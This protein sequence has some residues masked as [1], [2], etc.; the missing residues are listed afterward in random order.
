MLAN[1]GNRPY[2]VS[3]GYIRYVHPMLGEIHTTPFSSRST[4]AHVV[5]YGPEGPVRIESMFPLG[6]SG[7][8]LMDETGAPIFDPNFFSMAPLFDTFTHRTFPLFD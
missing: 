1:L 8:I 5:E 2:M 4:Y 7:T 6:E 3:R